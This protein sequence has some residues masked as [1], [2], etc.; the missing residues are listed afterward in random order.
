VDSS[1]GGFRVGSRIDPEEL[2]NIEWLVLRYPSIR[3]LLKGNG[4]L[5]IIFVFA[6]DWN[7]G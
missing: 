3:E 6:D 1:P 7:S 4:G 5:H 2:V